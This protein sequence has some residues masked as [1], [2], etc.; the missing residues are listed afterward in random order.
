M[1]ITIDTLHI[2]KVWTTTWECQ[3]EMPSLRI[4]NGRY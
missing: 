3:Y 4:L 1:I 2:N